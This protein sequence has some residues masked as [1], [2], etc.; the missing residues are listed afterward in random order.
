[1]AASKLYCTN[2][3]SDNRQKRQLIQFKAISPRNNPEE[4]SS[5]LLRGG[6]LKSRKYKTPRSRPAGGLSLRGKAP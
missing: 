4:R 6:S 2:T 3:F 5:Q 1:M